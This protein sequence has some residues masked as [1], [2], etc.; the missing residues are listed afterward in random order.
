[1]K[2]DR[3]CSQMPYPVYNQGMGMMP[4]PG[5]MMNPNVAPMMNPNMAPMMS[6]NMAPMM[7]SS[8]YSSFDTNSIE[9]R[10]NNLEKRVSTLE[11]NNSVSFTNKYNDGN[12]HMM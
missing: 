7:S 3:N 1:M 6:P 5:P 9:Q 12:Y 4:A 8:G 10:L 2:K 11:G